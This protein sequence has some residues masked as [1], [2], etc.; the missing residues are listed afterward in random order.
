M[1]SFGV[2]RSI[3]AV[4]VLWMAGYSS[5]QA[6][7]KAEALT[8]PQMEQVVHDYIMAHPEVV[9]EAVRSYDQKLK[10]AV[11]DRLR[12]TVRQ[13]LDELYGHS[14]AFTAE[15]KSAEQVTLVEFFDYRC[16]YCKKVDGTV[17]D[18]AKKPGV[19]I[20]YKDFPILGPESLTAARAALAA[21]KQGG[22]EKFHHAL[23]AAPT[24]TEDTIAKIA[25]ESG[26]DVAQLKQ[27][28]K[29]PEI[30]QT[31]NRNRQLAEKLNIQSTP[32]FIIG[33]ELVSGALPPQTLQSLIDSARRPATAVAPKVQHAGGF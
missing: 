5:L 13:N 24:L 22:Y 20:V 7:G 30:E 10:A 29:S 14:P 25:A 6:Q 3:L 16:G 11:K 8:T 31:L 19:R 26:L 33:T 9:L 15:D 2:S 1:N 17:A 21:D 12:D 28:M 32:T 4:G 18:L 23:L 27:D